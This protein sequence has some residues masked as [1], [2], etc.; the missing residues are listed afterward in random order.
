MVTFCM[1][2]TDAVYCVLCRLSRRSWMRTFRRSLR[3][4]ESIWKDRWR[5]WKR[6]WQKIPTSIGQTTSASCRLT[7]SVFVYV[8][9]QW[10][11]SVDSCYRRHVGG[12]VYT[13]VQQYIVVNSSYLQTVVCGIIH[14]SKHWMTI[15]HFSI[16]PSSSSSL[17]ISTTKKL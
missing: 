7:V 14:L 17:V 8:G 15:C 11:H 3:D 1:L 13:V 5:L 12:T 6:S 16:F 2:D 9:W 10:R 4:S